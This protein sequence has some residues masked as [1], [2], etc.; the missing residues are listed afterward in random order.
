MSQNLRFLH[1]CADEADAR[2]QVSFATTG[3][4]EMV[5]CLTC[6]VYLMLLVL[7]GRRPLKRSRVVVDFDA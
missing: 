2:K 6:N 4:E 7:P 3:K 5:L 1:A